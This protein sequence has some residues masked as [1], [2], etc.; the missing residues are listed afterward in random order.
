[1]RDKS[2][3][4]AFVWAKT[5]ERLTVGVVENVVVEGW[6]SLGVV[7]VW[8]SGFGIGEYCLSSLESDV[9]VLG[10]WKAEGGGS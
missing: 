3:V 7:W 2:D 9:E 6:G 10:L 1:M 5:W 8:V 4:E